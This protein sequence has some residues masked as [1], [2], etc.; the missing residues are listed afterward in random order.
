M[1]ALPTSII[2]TPCTHGAIVITGSMTRNIDD[3]PVARL[4]DLVNCPIHG[5]NPLVSVNTMTFTE[6][7]PTSVIG[8]VAQCGA[9]V[10]GG[11]PDV[12]TG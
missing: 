1:S 6:D 7:K 8:S 5:I 10:I 12:L 2:G 11:S 9:V 4:G 3:I